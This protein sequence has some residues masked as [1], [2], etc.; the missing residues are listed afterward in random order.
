MINGV[1]EQRKNIE[2]YVKNSMREIAPNL[3]SLIDEFLAARLLASAG[4]LEKLAKMS[5]S[6]IQLIGAEKALF[7]HLRNQGRA[8]KYGLLFLSSQ[9]QNAPDDKR[10]KI[11][12]V[13]ASKIMQAVRID[14]YSGRFEDQLRRE[15]DEE[16][17]RVLQ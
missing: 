14:F 10:G 16:I 7:R 15:M 6:T 9:V 17:R 5:A 2:N 1:V 11:A 3:S 13:L 4:S 12:R 8:P